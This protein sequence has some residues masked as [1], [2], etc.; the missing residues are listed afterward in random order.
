MNMPAVRVFD[1]AGIGPDLAS[2]LR[3]QATRIKRRIASTTQDL[4][5]IGRDLAAAKQQLKHGQFVR[6][7]EAEV[8]IVK[9]TAQAY[10]AAARLADSKSA[11]VA[12]LPPATVH[13]LAAK[14]TPPEVV[15]AVCT[16]AAAGDVL[17]DKVVEEMISEAKYQK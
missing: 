2:N 7:V 17:P 11:A 1:Y 8:G 6:W 16:K 4:I 5:D 9:R 14:S 10:M 13:R 15:D 3:Q 12:L